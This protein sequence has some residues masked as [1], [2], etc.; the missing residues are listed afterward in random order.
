LGGH[1]LARGSSSRAYLSC[2]TCCPHAGLLTTWPA[3]VVQLW[4]DYRSSST[5]RPPQRTD[6]STLPHPGRQALSSLTCAAI[7]LVYKGR[8]RP[9]C[10]STPAHLAR[11]RLLG[12]RTFA[13]I[14]RLS[15]I[16]TLPLLPYTMKPLRMF[17]LVVPLNKPGQ[18]QVPRTT[19]G[20]PARPP[21]PFLDPH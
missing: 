20:S 11:T 8:A 10:P 13:S 3:L 5:S 2:T 1:L 17:L 12:Q 4:L 7:P 18:R 14:P 6:G 19:A 15:S 16:F 9:A 21:P